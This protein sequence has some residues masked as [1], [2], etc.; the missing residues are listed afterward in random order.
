MG[1]V[2]INIVPMPKEKM[3]LFDRL[4]GRAVFAIEIT[5]DGKTDAFGP[6]KT[7]RDA[8]N[9]VEKFKRLAVQSSFLDGVPV[10]LCECTPPNLNHTR[11]DHCI[12][13]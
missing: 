5:S 3:S 2:T 4:S 10:Y 11:F 7:F 6:Y 12:V 8:E 13:R 1:E 9:Q